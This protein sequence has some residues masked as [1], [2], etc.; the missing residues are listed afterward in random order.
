MKRFTASVLE[1]ADPTSPFGCERKHWFA[2][3]PMQLKGFTGNAATELGDVVHKGNETFLETKGATNSLHPRA[4]PGKALIE[5]YIPRIIGIEHKF[6]GGLEVAGLPF[7][8]RIDL[9][10]SPAEGDP[11]QAEIVDWKTTSSI[12]KWAKSHFEVGIS[13]QTTVYAKWFYNVL[14]ENSDPLRLSMVYFQTKDAPRVEKRTDVV[15]REDVESRWNTAIVPLA[16]RALDISKETD[17][18][19]VPANLA[20]CDIAFGCPYRDR[21]PREVPDPFGL[22]KRKEQKMP[23]ILDKFK[24]IQT[25]ASGAPAAPPAPPP[26]P[27]P[28]PKEKP[29]PP[30]APPAPP[31][32][33]EAVPPPRTAA[34]AQVPPP[35]PTA[36]GGPDDGPSAPPPPP[37]PRGPGRPPGAKNKPKPT[38]TKPPDL[39]PG[40]VTFVEEPRV[41]SVSVGRSFTVNLG[42]Y[43]SA[44]VEVAMSAVGMTEAELA[45]LVEEALQRQL[46][47][48]NELA[49]AAGTGGR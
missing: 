41:T 15:T 22:S 31:P 10:A 34:P 23:S 39:T 28:P 33:F 18:N 2:E 11:V 8:G 38:F 49:K 24:Q 46:A 42:N 6:K 5:A 26:E 12:A 47:P 48:Y 25:T 44:K 17:I 27:V 7:A 13:T 32:V 9:L 35:L 16:L 37:K 1:T 29:L 36:P 21:C 14:A 19:K 40:E 30:P 43:Q 20:V 45:V 3:G 4:L